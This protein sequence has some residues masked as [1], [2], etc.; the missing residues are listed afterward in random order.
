MTQSAPGK[1]HREGISLMQLA[2]MFP[3]EQDAA[4]WFESLIWPAERGC[5]HCGSI[6]TREV[7]KRKPM[8]YWCTDCRSYFSVKTGTALSHS[9]LPL[10]KWAFA[11]YL[12]I[13]S[14]KGVSSMKLH[15]DIQVRQATAWFMLHRI[16]EAWAEPGAGGF[17]GPVEVDETYVGGLEANKHESQRSRARGGVPEKAPVIGV[18]DRGTG[19]VR[20]KAIASTDGETLRGFVREHAAPGAQVYSDGHGAYTHPSKASSSTQPSSTASAR[21]SSSKSTPTASSRSGRHSSGRTK[22]CTTRSARS[23]W[24]ATSSSLRGST[25]SA[26]RTR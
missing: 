22:A 17:G 7:P 23:T 11:I 26:T 21:T 18:K 15:R 4:D 1:A 9:K 24:T 14:L 3:T 2:E 6:K 16:R 13:T 20:A 25:T 8:P 19:E 12:E 5:G 10:R